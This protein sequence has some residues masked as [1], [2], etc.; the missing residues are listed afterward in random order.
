M[1]LLKRAVASGISTYPKI[2]GSYSIF[3][4]LPSER[5]ARLDGQTVVNLRLDNI[6]RADRGSILT[7]R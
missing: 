7:C 1:R 4:Q 3:Q 2:L 6:T 5:Q